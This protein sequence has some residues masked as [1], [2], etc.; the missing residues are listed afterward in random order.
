MTA[1]AVT[2]RR[3]W[4]GAAAAAALAA[5]G[6]AGL[7]GA[8][9]YV[10][11]TISPDLVEQAALARPLLVENVRVLDLESGALGAPQSLIVRS[12]RIAAIGSFGAGACRA[13]ERV[14]GEG[15]V[16]IPA[17]TDFHV[18]FA[19]SD[20]EA[21][22]AGSL[23]AP[24]SRERE[25]QSY[26]Y[27]GVTTVVEG[28]P[29]ALPDL[30]RGQSA[31]EVH[32]AG[33]LVTAEGGHPLPMIEALIPWP[34]SRLVGTRLAA[35]VAPG[36]ERLV[37]EQVLRDP[38]VRFLKIIYDNSI[39]PGSPKMSR[40]SLERLI[41][42]AHKQRKAAYVHVGS[43]E[44]AVEA[45]VAGAD[46]IMHV[47]FTDT[48]SP[49]Q[50]ERLAGTRAVFASTSQIWSWAASPRTRELSPLERKLMPAWA[51]ASFREAKGDDFSR[52]GDHHFAGGD[53][54]KAAQAFERN[55]ATNLRLLHRHGVTLVAGTDT[56]VPGLAAGASLHR[57][58]RRLTAAG[59]TP[60]ESLR[61]AAATPARLLG[62]PTGLAVAQE[63]DLLVLPGDPRA[64]LA[65]LESPRLI[66]AHG[67]IV[68]RRS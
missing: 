46:V 65:H 58:L 67:K 7:V 50:L 11:A 6:L 13:C 21:P 47:P 60:L 63:A 24:P 45:A 51:Q 34:L 53:V 27:S 26:L 54:R 2:A 49:Q 19:F 35:T 33:R 16:A 4:R 64:S 43:P 30:T 18:H 31:L 40:G 56:G 28:G 41:D 1:G 8:K 5:A 25:I 10:S 37:A 9:W 59:L 62:K 29:S 66:L 38:R 61:A 68:R 12:G 36:G 39:P 14:R 3:R 42:A 32:K 23:L 52:F 55:Q 15:G 20:G 48:F 17:L 44:E 22:W 57:E